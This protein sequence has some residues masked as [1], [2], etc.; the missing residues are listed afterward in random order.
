MTIALN[1]P[2]AQQEG[3]ESA[4]GWVDCFLKATYSEVGLLEDQVVFDL[5]L[6]DDTENRN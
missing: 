2:T 5:C 1:C 6:P 3:S 4:K